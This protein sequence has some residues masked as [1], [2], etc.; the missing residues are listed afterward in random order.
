MLAAW[1][2]GE[3]LSVL[4]EDDEDVLRFIEDGLIY[5]LPWGMEAVRVRALAT[6]DVLESGFGLDDFETGL[7]VPAV[8][9]GTLNRSAAVLMQA[10]FTSRL[11]AI[12][13]VADTAATF[14]D[15]NALKAWIASEPVVQL[16]A[17]QDWPTAATTDIWKAFLATFTPPERAKWTEWTYTDQVTWKSPE[18]I[19][20]AGAA[21]RIVQSP[22]DADVSLVLSPDH[23]LLGQLGHRLNPDRKGLLLS[24]VNQGRTGAA[25]RYAGPPDLT[26]GQLV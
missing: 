10:G 9:T 23:T 25:M 13:A 4:A 18:L 16:T 6:G 12:K 21:I 22:T 20:A 11:A 5:R 3:P 7:A 17:T 24:D 1:L 2:K 19:P 8:E 14:A 15:Y 26:P